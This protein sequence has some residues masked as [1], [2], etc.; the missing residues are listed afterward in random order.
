M[1]PYLSIA[2][3]LILATRMIFPYSVLVL[4]FF[5][6]VISSPY[7]FSLILDAPFY[8]MAIYFWSVYRPTLLPV[9]L[10]FISG[11]L[12]DLLS[13]TPL[14]LNAALFVLIRLVVVDQ[15]RFLLAQ[16]F[17]M[18]WLGFAVVN[19][20]YNAFQWLILSTLSLQ[21]MP[22]HDLW[23]SVLLGFVFFPV[24]SIV[25][26]ITRRIL[27]EPALAPNV[28]LGSQRKGLPL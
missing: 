13:G 6:G 8:L 15:R 22:L 5:M 11:I 18:V 17:I 24:L 20:I 25:L 23:T 19:F 26:H 4:L 9:W 14:G 3:R 27:P 12:L 21:F 16:S 28:T 10:V 7:P 1:G 2:D